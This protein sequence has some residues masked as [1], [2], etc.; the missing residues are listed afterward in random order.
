VFHSIVIALLVIVVLVWL[1]R[2]LVRIGP[3]EVGLIGKRWSATRLKGENPVAFHGEAGYQAK[4]LMP[5]LRYVIWPLFWVERKP[6]VQIPPGQIGIIVA[7]IGESLPEGSR[8]AIYKQAFGSFTDLTAFIEN[9]GQKGIQRKLLLPGAL[10]PLHPVAFVVLTKGQRFGKPFSGLADMKVPGDNPFDL[11]IVPSASDRDGSDVIGVVTSFEG[12][13]LEGGDIASRLGGF[14]DIASAEKVAGTPDTALIELI[15]ATK[16]H[17]HHN[18]QDGQAF[19][20]NGGKVGVQHDPLLPGSYAINPFLF[21]VALQPMLVVEQGQVAVIKSYVGLPTEN[22]SGDDFKFGALVKP[23]HRGVWREPIRTGKYAINPH[24]YSKEIVPTSILTLQWSNAPAEE[25]MLDK[26]L[27]PI[28]A[29]S[30]EGF[31][32]TMD[33]DVQ[34]HVPDVQAPRLISMTGTMQNLVDEIL[35]AAVGNHFRDKLQSMTAV[36]FIEERQGVQEQAY[37]HIADKLKEYA[38]VE[39]RGVYIQAM[40]MPKEITDVL[41]S[42]LV[43]AEQEDTYAAMQKA[44][45]ARRAS[46]Q[47][48]GI[49]DNQAELAKS[50]VSKEI[51]RNQAD[52]RKSQA[53]GEAEYIR[54]TASAEGLGKAEGYAKQVE[55]LGQ[56]GTTIVNSLGTLKDLKDGT[57]I[58]P[59]VIVG[60][61]G[62]LLQAVLARF[63]V[64]TVPA[65]TE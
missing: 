38:A 8:T 44:E 2:S 9:H 62:D 63:A 21:Q 11:Q 30:K 53:D 50:D 4:L 40:A 13:P 57:Q 15:L 6:W 51:A 14:D 22:T 45:V 31:E 24:C 29:K 54:K 34:I 12:A 55:V 3:T 59:Q 43:A 19:L 60:A 1:Q 61:G 17:L 58:M 46:E 18:Y 64:P 27:G 33:L 23:G 37:A 41:K 28:V 48:K 52:A 16:N 56:A 42:R 65:T 5:G 7:Q 47:A 39:T 49:A 20:D 25:H 26:N 36:Q 10:L 32:F 35:Q